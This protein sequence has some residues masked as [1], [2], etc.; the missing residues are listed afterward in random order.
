MRTTLKSCASP[1]A[2]MPDPMPTNTLVSSTTPANAS[3]L[4]AIPTRISPT[5]ILNNLLFFILAL[6]IDKNILHVHPKISRQ[7][8]GEADG[9]VVPS[10]FQG[11]DGLP[12][13]AHGLRQ[14]LLLDLPLLSYLFQAIF[15][16][17]L[18]PQSARVHA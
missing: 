5:E 13:H 4:T 10:I 7:L 16:D 6:L 15:Q 1:T 2:S 18:L 14:L 9:R 12:G 17:N 3:R 8:D 11:A